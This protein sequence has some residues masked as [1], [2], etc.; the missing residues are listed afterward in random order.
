MWPFGGITTGLKLN[1]LLDGLAAYQVVGGV[2]AYQAD[3]G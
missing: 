2:M 3:D 1:A